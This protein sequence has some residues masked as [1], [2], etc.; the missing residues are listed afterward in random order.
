MKS[1]RFLVLDSLRGICAIMVALFHFPASGV[2]VSFPIVENSWLFVDFFFVLSGFV[3]AAAYRQRLSEGFSPL[4]FMWVRF[5]R[6]Y[7]LHI[8]ILCLMLLSEVLLAAGVVTAG[9]EPFGPGKT[10]SEF[11]FA[12]T[13]FNCF[14]LTDELGWNGPSWSIGGEWWAYAAFATIEVAA[15]TRA[16]LVWLIVTGVALALSA[17]SGVPDR[18]FNWGV[19]RALLGFGIGTL[20]FTIHTRYPFKLWKMAS[21]IEIL[22]IVL[23]I[24]AVIFTPA[25]IKFATPLLFAAIVFTFARSDGVISDL[26]KVRFLVKLGTLSYSIY[27]WQVILQARLLDGVGLIFPEYINKNSGGVNIFSGPAWIGDALTISMLATLIAFSALSYRFIELPGQRFGRDRVRR[28][29]RSMVK[30]ATRRCDES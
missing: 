19:M 22:L 17:F 21:V 18:T 4:V 9:R 30:M 20:T 12:A 13:F 15:R 25:T 1:D 2:I 8:A 7:P 6:L 28:I 16:N 24:L 3:I 29:N 26:L 11:F 5:W 23:S 14:G 27:L 10:L